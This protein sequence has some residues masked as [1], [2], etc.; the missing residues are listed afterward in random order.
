MDA[1]IPCITSLTIKC[2]LTSLN[3]HFVGDQMSHI[4]A[5]IDEGKQYTG[6]AKFKPLRVEM[7]VSDVK[8][9]EV[10][11]FVNEIANQYADLVLSNVNITSDK[12]TFDIGSP[13]MEDLTTK[14]IKFRIEEYLTMNEQPFKLKNLT[15]A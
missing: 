11:Y 13:S 14:D 8:T 3:T 15:V 12:I 2:L 6:A 1:S 7:D 10:K 9:D 4:D 5:N